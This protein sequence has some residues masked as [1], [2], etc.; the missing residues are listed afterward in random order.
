[1]SDEQLSS[2]SINGA[3]NEE[4]SEI[5]LS[6]KDNQENEN[7]YESE[8]SSSSRTEEEITYSALEVEA[9]AFTRF[10]ERQHMETMYELRRLRLGERPV[11]GQE[12]R[13][14][15]ATFFDRTETP[16]TRPV[17]PPPSAQRDDIDALENRRCVS[18]IL[19]SA[20][21]RF[22]LENSIRR[23]IGT[24]TVANPQPQ[25]QPQRLPQPSQ[26]L[27]LERYVIF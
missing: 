22:D 24:R 23:T 17:P 18:T 1:M 26:P 3:T 8:C 11:T 4:N 9:D 10:I 27:N 16:S 25:P 13:Q 2:T 20:A 5:V 14:R 6:N 21:F 12:N 15:I 19:S 7:G